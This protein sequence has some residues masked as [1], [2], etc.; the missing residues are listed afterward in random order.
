MAFV[1]FLKKTR[2][3][4]RAQSAQ[5]SHPWRIRLERVRGKTWDVTKIGMANLVYNIRRLIFPRNLAIA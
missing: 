5:P 3:E 1:D 2:D 4:M